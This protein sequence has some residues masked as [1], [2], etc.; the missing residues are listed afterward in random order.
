MRRNN[1]YH[2]TEN[3]DHA[4]SAANLTQALAHKT[5]FA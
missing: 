3:F 2:N 5:A 1:W 4:P